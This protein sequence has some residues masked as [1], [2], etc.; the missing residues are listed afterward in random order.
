MRCRSGDAPSTAM[1]C[2]QKKLWSGWVITMLPAS[3]PSFPW[4]RRNLPPWNA[5]VGAGI[6][7]QTQHAFGD[8]V[9]HDLIGSTSQAQRG[10][11]EQC[12]LEDAGHGHVATHRRP[13]HAD[14]VQPVG[15]DI[16]QLV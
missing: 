1:D 15:Q 11:V 10:R 3:W 14:H 13:G 16:L 4:P 9:L 5:L 7:R 8:D 12:F 2:G 6:L